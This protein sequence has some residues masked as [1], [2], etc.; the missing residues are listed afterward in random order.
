MMIKPFKSLF[1]A[2]AADQNQFIE[3]VNKILAITADKDYLINDA[4]RVQVYGYEQE[5]DRMVYELYGLTKKEI[6]IVED[7]K[8]T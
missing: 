5:I 8:K 1:I 3:Y 2:I 4:K 6:R 7:F